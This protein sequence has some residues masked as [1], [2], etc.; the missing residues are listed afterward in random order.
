[1][2]LTFFVFIYSE[3]DLERVGQAIVEDTPAYV[4]EQMRVKLYKFH[5]NRRPPYYGTWRKKSTVIK[6]TKPFEQDKVS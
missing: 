4:R 3:D 2:L 5:D 6:P 1:M